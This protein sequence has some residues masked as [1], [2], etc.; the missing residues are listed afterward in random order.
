[1]NKIEYK[2]IID[3]HPGY[4]IKDIIESMQ[5]SKNE[6]A[7]KLNIDIKDLNNIINGNIDITYEMAEKLHYI[8][9]TSIDVWINIQQN[10]NNTKNKIN[11]VII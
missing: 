2:N 9:G 5:I 3:F 7:K 8:L 4:Y 1:M 6:F 11:E 10:Y